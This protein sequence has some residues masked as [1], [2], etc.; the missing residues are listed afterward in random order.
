MPRW[1]CA[2]SV[3]PVIVLL[4]A[5]AEPPSKEMNQAQGAIDAARAAGAEQYATPEFTAAVDA[6]KRSEEAAALNDYRLALTLAIDSRSS[7]QKAARAAVEARAKARGDAERAVAEV[8]TLLNQAVER[9]ASGGRTSRRIPQEPRLTIQAAQKSMQ[10]ANAAL[11]SD[12]YPR[13]IALT[14]GLAARLQAAMN[15]LDTFPAEN[16]SRRRR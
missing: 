10:E 16:P 9:L 5:C 14:Q 7:A 2:F 8:N 11:K 4:A 15:A 13:A 6:L 3:L 1:L 12:D